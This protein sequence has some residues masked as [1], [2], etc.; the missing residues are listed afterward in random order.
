MFTFEILRMLAE[1]GT[2]SLNF[3]QPPPHNGGFQQIPVIIQFQQYYSY[4][5]HHRPLGS[6]R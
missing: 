1:R 5:H 2:P 3:A 4:I 6:G